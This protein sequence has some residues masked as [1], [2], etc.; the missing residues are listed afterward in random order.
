MLNLTENRVVLYS[1]GLALFKNVAYPYVIQLNAF[2]SILEIFLCVFKI[3]F[4]F[5]AVLFYLSYEL[6][7]NSSTFYFL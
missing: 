3:S 7:L 2:L 5:N 1:F 6:S 4:F